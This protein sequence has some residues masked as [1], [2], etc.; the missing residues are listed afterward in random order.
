MT[1]RCLRLIM[2]KLLRA[3]A[4]K[5]LHQQGQEPAALGLPGHGTQGGHCDVHHSS[6]APHPRG[7]W[8]SF[9]WSRM[10]F[11]LHLCCDSSPR[12]LLRL[13]GLVHRCWHPAVGSGAHLL[14][15]QNPPQ[16]WQSGPW[17]DAEYSPK[18]K[19]RSGLR[20]SLGRKVAVMRCRQGGEKGLWGERRPT[21][22]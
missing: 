21:S 5:E 8:A 3:G 11:S 12:L 14:A 22:L 16:G 2:L 19:K 10:C 13:L 9:N 6:H 1:G 17:R 4:A 20:G 18:R 7:A 15:S